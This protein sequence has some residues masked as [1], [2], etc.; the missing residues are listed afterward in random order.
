MVIFMKQNHNL[1]ENHIDIPESITYFYFM[2]RCLSRLA[3]GPFFCPGL[4]SKRRG[5][6]KCEC[7][8]VIE[9]LS[10]SEIALGTALIAAGVAWGIAKATVHQCQTDIETIKSL[11]LGKD[12]R[13]AYVLRGECDANYRDVCARADRSSAE[14]RRMFDALEQRLAGMDIKRDRAREQDQKSFE[15]IRTDISLIKQRINIIHTQEDDG[16]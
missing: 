7:V 10:P 6:R 4:R 15:L 14:T 8:G 2:A 12:G 9:G 11:I 3:I 16:K 1:A 5:A 13:S